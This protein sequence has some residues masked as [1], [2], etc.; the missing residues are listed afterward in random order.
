MIGQ[1]KNNR[2]LYHQ[3]NHLIENLIILLKI[4]MHIKIIL[5]FFEKYKYPGI[6]VFWS[7]FQVCF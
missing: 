7:E 6:A 5:E 4:Q 3:N 2:I 1:Q